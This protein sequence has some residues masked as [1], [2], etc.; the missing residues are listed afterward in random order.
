MLA[1]LILL[2]HFIYVGFVI[3]G[4]LFVWV[5]AYFQWAWIRNFR[6]RVLHL[7]ATALVALESVFGILCPLT[8]WENLLRTSS[9]GYQT[10]FMQHWIHKILFYDAP[11]Y[12]FTAGYV[13]FTCLVAA[14]WYFIRPRRG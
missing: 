2:I 11:E 10:G 4:F 5:G 12:V 3:A 1:D 8:V 9:G 14:S 7:A 13:V 6:F